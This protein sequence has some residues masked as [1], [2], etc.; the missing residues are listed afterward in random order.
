M[1]IPADP[2]NERRAVPRHIR[3]GE[4][5][6]WEDTMAGVPPGGAGR[7]RLLWALIAAGLAA[8]AG[9]WFALR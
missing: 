1:N 5:D 2:T 4:H 9:A 6:S 8:L 7:S 3:D